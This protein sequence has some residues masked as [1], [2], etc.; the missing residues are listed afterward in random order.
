LKVANVQWALP[1][2]IIAQT[3]EYMCSDM[4]ET[5]GIDATKNTG[6]VFLDANP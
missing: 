5:Q 4:S 3:E 2:D 6:C 1:G